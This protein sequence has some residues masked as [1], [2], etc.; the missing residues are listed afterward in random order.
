[1]LKVKARNEELM[2]TYRCQ[3]EYQEKIE[4]QITDMQR[5]LDKSIELRSKLL[6]KLKGLII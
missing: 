3:F 1:M 2:N 5:Q 6:E 4:S